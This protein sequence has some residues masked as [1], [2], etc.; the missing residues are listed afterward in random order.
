MALNNSTA[1]LDQ[2]EESPNLVRLELEVTDPISVA[3]LK[4][5]DEPILQ[6]ERAAEALKVGAIAIQSANPTLDTTMVEHK[7]AELEGRLKDSLD[8][9]QQ[10]VKEEL[11]CYF[12][13]N[14]GTIPKSLNGVFGNDG[15]LD[16]TFA[17]FFE[18]TEGKV[19][20]LMESQ[21]GP[22]SIFGRNLDPRNKDGIIALIEERVQIL[23]E[24]KMDEVLAQFSLDSDDSAMSRI[25]SLMSESFERLSLSLG[26]ETAK[27]KEAEKG[28]VKG[29]EFEKELYEEF[30]G[31]GRLL[32]D[33]TE[34]VRGIFGAIRKKTGDYVST[35]GETAGAPGLRITV[36]V[37]NSPY[38]LKDAVDELQVAKKNREASVGIFV[39]A[40]GTEP[41]EV[42]DFRRVGEDFF[43][44]VD[45]NALKD[46]KNLL[47]FDAAYRIARALVIAS[48]RKEAAGQSD[49]PKIQQQID[50]LCSWSDRIT[51]FSTKAKTIQKNGD[52]IEQFLCD[53]KNEMDERLTEIVKSLGSHDSEVQEL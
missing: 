38:K 13:D 42:G 19:A 35:L 1:A 24:K 12:E 45:R 3:Y 37:K 44:T 50:A 53:L 26:I 11:A 36:E 29:I 30:A 28:H 33:E 7:F 43:V 32:G 25:Q 17:S 10:A 15:L 4:Q 49:I 8:E 18:P 51:G 2:V 5:F 34:F 52:L 27:A 20:R 31:W 39:F 21:I 16:R 48:A 23:V 22:N 14:E 46:G 9:F 47:F 41:S 6:K 40:K